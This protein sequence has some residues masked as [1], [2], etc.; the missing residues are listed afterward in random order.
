[1]RLSTSGLIADPETGLSNHATLRREGVLS[2]LDDPRG[3]ALDEARKRI[4]FTEKA[5][6]IYECNMDGTN[7]TKILI[8]LGFSGDSLFTWHT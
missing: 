1:M 2:G 8:D 4:F 6:R 5:G 3:L 7:M